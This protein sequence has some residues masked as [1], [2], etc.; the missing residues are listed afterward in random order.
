MF[1]M[2]D[3]LTKLDY[4]ALHGPMTDR[5]TALG[6]SLSPEQWV[7]PSLCEG[8][9]VCDVYGHMTYGGATPMYRVLPR[10]LFLYRGNLNRG[11]GVES[12]RYADTHMQDVVMSE[13]DRSS[14]HPV[15]I[16]KVIKASELHMDHI[17]HEMDIRRSLGIAGEWGD[18]DL[19]AALEAA[20]RTKTPLIAPAKSATGLRLVATDLDWSFGPVDGP[21]VAGPAEDLLLAMCGR[22]AG[23]ATLRGDGVAELTARI[24]A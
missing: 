15:G 10:L 21:E 16:G 9:R 17:V 14:R 24:S 22:P 18:N 6:R 12:V 4:Q 1:D 5:L 3:T 19:R 11:S 2:T 23:L 8:W 7:A 20:V 13:F